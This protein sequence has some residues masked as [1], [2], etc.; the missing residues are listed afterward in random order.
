MTKIL[1]RKILTLAPGETTSFL[2]SFHGFKILTVAEIEGEIAIFYEEAVDS[3]HVKGRAFTV[4]KCGEYVDGGE[5][6]GSVFHNS[7]MHH[8]Y[9]LGDAEHLAHIAGRKPIL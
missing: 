8:V 5:Y 3:P 9:Q 6:I 7:T 1:Q 4:K 2:A